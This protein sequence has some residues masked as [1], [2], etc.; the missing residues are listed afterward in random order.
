MG[1]TKNSTGQA[2]YDAVARD[3]R[4][5]TVRMA[6]SDE[7]EG[8]TGWVVVTLTDGFTLEGSNC[9]LAHGVGDLRGLLARVESVE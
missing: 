1:S 3:C 7:C 9:I 4:I 5:V 8:E 6:T 2:K